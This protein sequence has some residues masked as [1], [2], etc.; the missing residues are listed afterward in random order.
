MR[1]VL[2]CRHRLTQTQ[3]HTLRTHVIVPLW[4]STYLWRWSWWWAVGYTWVISCHDWNRNTHWDIFFHENKTINNLPSSILS[5]KLK[6]W[7]GTIRST[8][9]LQYITSVVVVLN[10]NSRGRA[11]PNSEYY[12]ND[13]NSLPLIQEKWKTYLLDALSCCIFVNA[14]KLFRT[15]LRLARTCRDH[16]E[17]RITQSPVIK[18]NMKHRRQNRGESS[19]VQMALQS[20]RHHDWKI[21]KRAALILDAG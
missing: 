4:L 5:F 15:V 16:N 2:K 13:L 14:P 21:R 9:F 8:M 19:P 1:Y 17:D 3:P 11:K 7:G 20:Y 10:M 18:D 12:V 6:Q